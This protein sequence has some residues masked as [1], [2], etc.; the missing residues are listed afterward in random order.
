MEFRIILVAMLAAAVPYAGA[1]TSERDP[2]VGY[3]YPAGGRQATT[4]EV[5]AGGQRLA[6]VSGAVVTGEGVQVSVVKWY[7]PV[8]PL[9]RDQRDLLQK[10]LKELREKRAAEA[11]PAA[12]GTAADRLPQRV[13]ARPAAPPATPDTADSPPPRNAARHRRKAPPSPRR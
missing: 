3:L 8:R 1:Q 12:A 4:F 11:G 10:R 6:G 2:R 5:T 9:D 7:R 13:A